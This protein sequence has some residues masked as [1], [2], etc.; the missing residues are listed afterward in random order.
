MRSVLIL[1]CLAG[2]A[3][4][5]DRDEIAKLV[6]EQIEAASD[7]ADPADAK[8]P[9]ADGARIA[10]SNITLRKKGY[11]VPFRI[12]AVFDKTAD[13]K[14]QLVHAHLATPG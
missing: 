12:F 11:A 3:R 14:W 13:G 6:A 1:M 9:Y 4:A 5:S 7:Q 2:A 10:I 8:T